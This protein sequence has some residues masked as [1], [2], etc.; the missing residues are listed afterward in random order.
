MD[1]ANNF[2][3]R[4]IVF[5]NRNYRILRLYAKNRSLKAWM[6]LFRYALKKA[7][8]K[9]IPAF[10]DIG[11]TYKCQCDC[12]HCAAHAFHGGE[13]EEMDTSQLK[14]LIDQAHSLGILEV[15]FSGGEPLLRKDMIELVRYAHE[16]GFII[17]FNTNGLLL[18][19]E[20]A[21]E[22]KEAGV[23]QVGVSIDSAEP[24]GHNALRQKNGVF[25][26]AL[27][28]IG[29]LKE[30]GLYFQILTYASKENVKSGLE[31]IIRLGKE[32]DALGVFIFFPIAVGRW[33]LSLDQVLTPKERERVREYY[34]LKLVHLELPTSRTN[35][36][37]FDKLVIYV[38]AQGDVTPCPFV[39]FTLG[40]LSD[41]TLSELWHG[42][43][44]HLDLECR[45][46]CPMNNPDTRKDLERYIHASA[47]SLRKESEI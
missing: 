26:K 21:V 37:S 28:G 22:L 11:V 42:Y 46:L 8:G 43:V 25:Q 40:N 14:D 38:T 18:T 19:R 12:V 13:R 16:L 27:E 34:D 47:A 4:T 33:D 29:Y 23:N 1:S 24:E 45:G 5:F 39:P 20:R 30:A 31:E 9:S 10:I 35:C 44:D 6:H 15:I 32:R 3:L 7:A 2:R 36:C 41:H 17:R